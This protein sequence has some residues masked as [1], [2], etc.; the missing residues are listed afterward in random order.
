MP[1]IFLIKKSLHQQQQTLLENQKRNEHV[2]LSNSLTQSSY[3]TQSES[4]SQPIVKQQT[5]LQSSQLYF[6]QYQYPE[7][8]SSQD[9]NIPKIKLLNDKNENHRINDIECSSISSS[10]QV[11]SKVFVKQSTS[12]YPLP[13]KKR[14]IPTYAAEPKLHTPPL[15]SR[16]KFC[17]V[18]VIQKT[19]RSIELPQ[20]FLEK[21][22]DKSPCMVQKQEQE[23]VMDFHMSKKKSNLDLD[24][25]RTIKNKC[26]IMLHNPFVSELKDTNT[27]TTPPNICKKSNSGSARLLGN[28]TGDMVLG[29]VG[30][31]PDDNVKQFNRHISLLPFDNNLIKSD[32]NYSLALMNEQLF[33]KN[34]ISK[35]DMSCIDDPHK[36][37]LLQH[38]SSLLNIKENKSYNMSKDQLTNDILKY[39]NQQQIQLQQPQNVDTPELPSLEMDSNTRMFVP[40][41]A[42]VSIDHTKSF[43]AL[44]LQFPKNSNNSTID[45]KILLNKLGLPNDY[46]L[47]FI[48]GGYGIKNPLCIENSIKAPK[49]KKNNTGVIPSTVAMKISVRPSITQ[50][51]SLKLCCNLCSKTFKRP[52][53]LERHIQIHND[54]NNY[55]CT[56]CGK[57]FYK[58]VDLEKHI[59]THKAPKENKNNTQVIPSTV[60]LP[61]NTS[62]EPPITEE[63]SLKLCCNLC[64][65][66]F[67][68][69]GFLTRH[70][71]NHNDMNHIQVN[72]QPYKRK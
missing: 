8:E 45:I 61:M 51:S 71:R 49:K 59:E 31:N 42:S 69:Q 65:K 70:I 34:N 68:K 12:T 33:F 9:K 36:Q 66:T 3:H 14:I 18:S 32:G 29:G 44:P 41:P 17:R 2:S 46:P 37:Y 60:I 19:P 39:S 10:N 7:T 30:M 57:G 20:N 50:D 72:I 13:P 24:I 64:S 54:M 58:I 28:G 43:L 47:E 67:K 40:S 38:N 1:K 26:S 4:P 16:P 5:E 55:L 63:R 52:G 15:Q 22:L 48:N 35:Q 23:A 21:Q 53:F 25:V 62:S 27:T 56:F 11:S 6:K